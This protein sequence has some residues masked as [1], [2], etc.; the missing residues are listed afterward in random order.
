[1]DGV[2]YEYDFDIKH[3]KGKE[4]KVE[5]VL[6]RNTHVMHVATI[7]TRT[8]NLKDNIIEGSVKNEIYQQV[9]EG[10]K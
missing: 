2:L 6:S 4:N 3:I 1:M 7:N 8:S 5:D 10:L 9:K